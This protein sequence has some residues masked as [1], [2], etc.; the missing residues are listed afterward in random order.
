MPIH[1]PNITGKGNSV[2]AKVEEKS[3][4]ILL[5][6]RRTKKFVIEQAAKDTLDKSI[7]STLI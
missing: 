7:K 2:L 1:L 5:K 3:E 6:F 4:D